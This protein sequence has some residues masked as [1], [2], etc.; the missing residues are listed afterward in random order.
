MADLQTLVDALR[1]LMNHLATLDLQQASTARASLQQAFPVDGAVC[2][3]LRQLFAEGR[4]AGWL[5]HKE[6]NDVRFSRV[7]KAVDADA[8][9]VDAVHMHGPGPGHTHGRGEVDLCFALD[10]DARF[11]G[12]PQGW[13][14]YPPGSWHEPTVTA[15]RMDILYFLPGGAITFGPRGA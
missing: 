6:A 7:V 10:D 4:E 2:Q 11:D 14:V 5:V 15:G 1:P 3:S 13:V 9:S 12:Q 8:W